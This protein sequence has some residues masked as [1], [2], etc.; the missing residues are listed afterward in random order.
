LNTTFKFLSIAAI[1]ALAV[2]PAAHASEVFNTPLTQGPGVYYGNTTYNANWTVNNIANRDGSNLAL[3]LEEITRFVGPT[4][5]SG[6]N[7]FYTPSAGPLANWDFAFSVNSGTD[8]L[9]TIPTTPSPFST[10]PPARASASIRQH[11]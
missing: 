10:P 8:P 4:T 7:Y 11:C 5:P 1:L 2:A 6:N 9:S 3:G